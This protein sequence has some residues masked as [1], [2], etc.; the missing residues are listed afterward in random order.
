MFVHEHVNFERLQAQFSE[1]LSPEQQ[2][3]FARQQGDS[4]FMQSLANVWL[5]SQYAFDCC[6]R[7]PLWLIA[8]LTVN[9]M[10][11]APIDS[12]P[13]DD[14]IKQQLATQ[15]AAVAS[16]EQLAQCLRLFRQQQMLR[17]IWRDI[18][19]RADT[20]QTTAALSALADACVQQALAFLHPRFCADYG[21][22]YNHHGQ[23]QTLLVLGMGKLGAFEL[24]LSSDI[25]LIFAYEEAGDTVFGAPTQ[26][27]RPIPHQDFFTHLARRLIAALDKITADGF[28]FRVDMR[29]RPYGDSG[30]LVLNYSAME[31]YYQQQGR[32]WERYAMIKVRLV[33]GDETQAAPLLA[34]LRTF[35]Y[36]RYLDFSAIDALREMKAL[37]EHDV[38]RR[39]LH[40]NIK[41]GW[42][43]IREVEFIAQSFQLI[44]GGRDAQL[45]KA[46]LLHTLRYLAEKQLLANEDVDA[47]LKAYF[48]L[49]DIEHL[50]QAWR[51][52]QTQT[53][54]RDEV[55]QQRLAWLLSFSGWDAFFAQLHTCRSEVQRVFSALI[56]PPEE[57]NSLSDAPLSQHETWQ[58]LWAG[59]E[60]KTSEVEAL[61]A[62]G[63]SDA[64]SLQPLLA[65]WR[66]DK[67]RGLLPS[68]SQAR[69]NRLMPLLLK[70]LSQHSQAAACFARLLP[71]LRAV[72]RRSA[73][74]VLLCEN[75]AALEQLLLLVD[76]SSWIAEQLAEQPVLLDELLDTRHLYSQEAPTRKEL[77]D[78]L[79]QQMLRVPE[80]DM[81][82]QMETLRLFKL[83]HSL[84]AA[85]CEITQRLPLMKISD[86]LT[87]LAEVILIQ[88]LSLAWK[89]LIDKHGVPTR[90]DGGLCEPSFIIVAYGKLGG[91]ELAYGSDIDLVFIHDADSG[92]YTQDN[93]NTGADAYT[94]PTKNSIENSIFYARLG[95]KIIHIL[96]TRTANG[97]LYDVDMRLRPSGNSGLL[98]SSLASFRRY[99]TQDAW[100]WEH[101]ALVR[102]RAVAGCP[103]LKA[104]FD[105]VRAE[106]LGLARDP[107]KLGREVVAMRNKMRA[108]LD[109]SN[110]DEI[111]L[112]QGRG[113][114][115][116][117]EFLV[118]YAT[119]AWSHAH[120]ALRCWSDNIRILEQLANTGLMDEQETLALIAAYLA[121]RGR[122]HR[123][124]LLGLAA[125][126]PVDQLE[127]E[128]AL[129]MRIWQKWLGI[130]EVAT[131][132][133]PP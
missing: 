74:L 51:D 41:L 60:D 75:P 16:E 22:P 34:M 50:L 4:V 70:A 46:S 91:L 85:A 86:Y 5:G 55:Q 2:A 82:A 127:K 17:I 31:Q 7:Q 98:V 102:A 116:D 9:D 12:Q 59:A 128:R 99:Q 71:L 48:F 113:A 25:D 15:L 45:Q 110:K 29:L 62:C 78:T 30:A 19:R 6:C 49:R 80:H 105:D 64:E 115:V 56:A 130:Y 47:L 100:T 121:L 111:D 104:R 13:S 109:K 83:S 57:N 131:I 106:V 84:R 14:E 10:G 122:G 132:A 24:N 88:V 117:L 108:Q 21:T 72:L 76:A 39:S 93:D 23:V 37:I 90:A 20:L 63:F 77:S 58:Q 35:T 126:I 73:Y 3:W 1:R 125:R 123:C 36:R 96:A 118:Q 120:P 33:A 112:K 94:D 53:L 79:R 18:T 124:V 129:I 38:Q 54:P 95:Q 87:F 44:Y 26:G 114:I 61:K 27:K 101:Q 11:V 69:L 42:G 65:A 103:Q 66:T 52:E 81:E 67:S 107:D 8:L 40:D 28:V 119:L 89:S 92:G 97:I 32:D 133:N 43:G 68:D